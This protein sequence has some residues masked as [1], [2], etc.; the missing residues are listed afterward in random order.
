MS[1]FVLVSAL[2][3]AGLGASAVLSAQNAPVSSPSTL[4][5]AQKPTEQV[6]RLDDRNCLRHTGSLIPAKKGQCLPVSGR[7]YSQQDIQRTG[8]PTLGSA[9]QALDPAVTTHGH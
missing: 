5:S 6:G 1:R 2:A 4:S 7:S 9:L 8:E 3:F